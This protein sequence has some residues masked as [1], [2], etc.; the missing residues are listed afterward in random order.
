VNEPGPKRIDEIPEIVLRQS[1]D[2]RRIQFGRALR[3]LRIAMVA[4]PWYELPPR[5][6]GGLELICSALVD[7][8]VD[9]GHDVTLFAA[10]VR[11]GTKAEL[12]TTTAEP[13]YARLG[14]DLPAALHIARVNEYIADGRFDVVHDHTTSGPL[15]AGQR[16]APT[17]VTVHGPADGEFGDFLAVLGDAVHPVAISHSQ[18]RR[19]PELPWAGTVHNGIAP[20]AFTPSDDRSGPVLW[21]A[22]FC[23]D[24][25]PDLAIEACRAAGLPLVLAGKCNESEEKRYLDE[26]VRPLVAD[27]VE[28]VLNGDRATTQR[29]LERARCLIMP[30]RWHEPFGMVMIEA[31]ATG[32]PVVAL[33]RGSV[34]EIVRPGVTGII[35]DDP[36]EL[37]DAL[38]RAADLDPADC[39]AQV[40]TLFS[41]DRMARRYERVYRR[42]LDG[43]RR[44]AGGRPRA[45]TLARGLASAPAMRNN[46][47]WAPV[48]IADHRP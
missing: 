44:T 23:P 14:A 39:V 40:R 30:I 1:P 29:L 11:N 3:P 26:T 32:T 6:Y 9:R 37:P 7:A 18:R 19:R 15:T 27:D 24:K 4:P 16:R 34:P 33:R 47:R 25:G 8:L 42:V 48:R 28:L 41:A 10:G 38:I 13:Q 43:G 46:G 45:A 17:V 31:M 20:D 5:G 36:T 35:C 12:V 22:R 21:L 2:Q